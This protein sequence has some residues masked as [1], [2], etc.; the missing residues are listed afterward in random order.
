VDGGRRDLEEALHVGLGGR[1][2]IDERVHVDER[3]VLA[4]LL[5]EAWR[6]DDAGHGAIDLIKGSTKE[7][8]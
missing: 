3:E 5:G 4:L 8:P 7:P 2:P 1:S 6:L